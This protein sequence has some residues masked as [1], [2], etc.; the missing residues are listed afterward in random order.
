MTV[1]GSSHP[2]VFGMAMCDGSIRFASFFVDPTLWQVLGGKS[3]GQYTS[4]D[5]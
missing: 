4:S 1:F 2:S 3:D 5:F